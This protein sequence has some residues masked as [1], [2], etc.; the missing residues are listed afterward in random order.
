M[1]T[2]HIRYYNRYVGCYLDK[3][4]QDQHQVQRH[5]ADGARQGNE[6]SKEWQQTRN[7]GGQ[8]HVGAAHQEADHEVVQGVGSLML[9]GPDGLQ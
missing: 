5:H 7:K 9:A 2:V 8:H 1:N 6:V 4:C 3:Q